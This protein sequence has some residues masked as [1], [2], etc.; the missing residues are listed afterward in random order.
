[1]DEPAVVVGVITTVHGLRGEVTVHNRSD[2]PDRWTAGSV[3]LLQ[4]GRRLTI[5][6]S[7]AHGRRLLVK[8]EGVDDRVAAEAL[9][10]RT[11]LVPESWLPPL[12]PGE[13][14]AHDL[15]G[16]TVVTRSGRALGVL[17]E[18]VA[19]PANDIWIARD[20]AGS[21][22]LIPVLDEFLVEVDPAAGRIVVEDV[23]GLTAP[24]DGDGP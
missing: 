1:M 20:D 9:R 2:N 24:E 10:G 23:P 11:V 12:P 5:E 22:T 16:C 3:V 7:R 15:E 8:F 13:W 18:V 6:T 21:E 17:A 4:D 19:N 14:W